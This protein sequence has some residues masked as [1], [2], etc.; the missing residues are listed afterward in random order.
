MDFEID[1]NAKA[2]LENV[3][4]RLNVALVEKRELETERLQIQKNYLRAKKE[5]KHLREQLYEAQ[6]DEPTLTKENQVKLQN[7]VIV[8]EQIK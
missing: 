3:M 6:K 7:A 4:N 2:T 5:A 1:H 8:E